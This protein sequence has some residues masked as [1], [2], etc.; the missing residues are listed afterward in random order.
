MLGQKYPV[1]PDTPITIGW[2]IDG[3]VHQKASAWK[4]THRSTTPALGRLTS[5]FP[6]DLGFKALG[7]SHPTS[8][9][10]VDSGRRDF[11]AQQK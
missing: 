11:Q 1:H 6:W 7:L 4:L 2:T 10:I 3:R 9:C 5:E 8:D